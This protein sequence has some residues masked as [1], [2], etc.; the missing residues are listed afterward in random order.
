[1]SVSLSDNIRDLSQTASERGVYCS[2][3]SIPVLL[4]NLYGYL[5]IT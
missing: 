1:M 5:T 2:L 4:V 3:V